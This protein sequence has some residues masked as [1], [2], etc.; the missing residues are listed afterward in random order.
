MSLQGS[1]KQRKKSFVVHS[2]GR[3]IISNIIE[4][5]DEEKRQNSLTYPLNEATKRAAYYCD[6]SE[7]FSK[8]LKQRKCSPGGKPVSYTHLDVYKRQI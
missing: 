7:S 8:Y 5:C 1:S 4:K 6:K 3:K 2:E